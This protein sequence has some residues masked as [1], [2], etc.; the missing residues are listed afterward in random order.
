MTYEKHI[1]YDLQA[2]S[3]KRPLPFIGGLEWQWIL[4]RNG[5]WAGNSPFN[6]GTAESALDA[7]RKKLR[8]RGA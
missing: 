3:R 8:E 4:Y 2:K 5:N 1:G 7:G 6:Y